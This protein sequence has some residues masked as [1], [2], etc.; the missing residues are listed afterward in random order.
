MT[1]SPAPPRAPGGA[2]AV[3]DRLGRLGRRVV[4][5]ALRRAAA[6]FRSNELTDRAAALTYYAVLSLFPALLVLV[7]LLSVA[8]PAV[9]GHVV[10]HLQRLVPSSARGTVSDA[11]RHLRAGAG[12]G[13]VLAVV[14]LLGAL[15][16]A[17]GYVAAFIR[18][19][20]ATYGMP[21]GRP[22][23]R[24]LLVRL[25]VT[26]GLVALVCASALIVVFT[27]GVARR[28]G[29]ALGVGHT[30]LTV[31]SIGKWPVLVV[32]ATMMISLL[33]RT[34][35]NV[36][37]R[38]A[39]WITA[40]SCLALSIWLV[41][42]AGF[43]LYVAHFSS[44]NRAYGTLAGVIVFL[45]WLWIANVA[46]LLGLAFDAELLRARGTEGPLHPPAARPRDTRAWHGRKHHTHR[47]A[48]AT[49]RNTGGRRGHG[50]GG[51]AP[52]GVGGGGRPRRGE[53]G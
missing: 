26:V 36:R 45:V 17:S 47:K 5:T 7:S 38:G 14:G 33:Y 19:A 8:D 44:Y 40:G 41:A 9:A 28:T 12:A 29:A 34:T 2:T 48:A 30:A 20:N 49:A 31:W 16:T 18:A 10:N 25:G 39:R 51:D 42:S 53:P 3:P 32:L 6:T 37:A 15:W 24:V 13:S 22:A 35:P 50:A 23:W 27:G 4:G 11:V 46:V 43:A 52:G 1:D 21:E